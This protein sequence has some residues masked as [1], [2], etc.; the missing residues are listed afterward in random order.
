MEV[1]EVNKVNEVNEKIEDI[2][3]MSDLLY[4]SELSHFKIEPSSYSIIFHKDDIK[5]GEL[6]FDTGKLVFTG[7][8]EKSA[9]IFLEYI[10]SSFNQKLQEV[11]EKRA[12]QK[13]KEAID[14]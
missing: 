4:T 1:N 5:I 10:I 6:S 12:D 9:E 3:N 8:T 2:D 14:G 13:I 7:D 11:I